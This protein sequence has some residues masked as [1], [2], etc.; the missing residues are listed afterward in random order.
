MKTRSLRLSPACAFVLLS[1]LLVPASFAQQKKPVIPSMGETMEISIVNVD[2]FVTDK[3]GNRVRGLKKEDFEI[4]ENG[5]KQPISNFA[6]YTSGATGEFTATTPGDTP[7]ESTVSA[8]PPQ[9]RTFMVFL[10]RMKLPEHQA[11]PFINSIKD[12][13]HKSVRPG[14]AVAVL[15]WG[16]RENM[17]LDFTGNMQSV[18]KTLDAIA[19]DMTGARFDLGQQL[20]EDVRAVR[21]FEQEVAAMAGGASATLDD[22]TAGNVAGNI[23]A[24]IAL[25]E[26]RRKVRAVNAA[27]LG[28]AGIEGKK[29]L[30]LATNRLGEY[31]GA[32]FFYAA[33]AD[34]LTPEAKQRF[35]TESLLKSMIDNANASGV[36]IYPLYAPG[37]SSTMNDASNNLTLD[38]RLD[39]LTLLNE[40]FALEQIAKKTGGLTATNVSDIVKLLPRVQEDVSDYYSLAY[41]IDGTKKDRARD[42]LV[43]TKNPQLQVRT[44]RQYVEK[45][46][47]TRMK[48]RVL[49]TLFRPVEQPPIAITATLGQPKKSGRTETVPLAVRV[50]I[51]ALTFIPQ[52]NGKMA[53]AF[54]VYVVTGAGGVEETSEITFKT[55]PFDFPEAQVQ[56]AM[57]GHFT[58]NL[59]IVVNKAADRIAVGVQDELS[60]Q[61]GLLRLDLKAREPQRGTH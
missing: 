38:P 17:Q 57:A 53:G 7:T 52:G 20:R 6:E 13:L 21:Q 12:F 8:A 51:K 27:I 4:V 35:S 31:A 55:Q 23:Q 22:A 37:L 32:E 50:P 18:D 58:Y 48:D 16:E 28:M 1:F 11:R 9:K 5:R 44:R 33:G 40:T 43:K 14:D 45:S 15:I 24:Q 34:T 26:I 25:N 59:D 60:K 39:H 36:T 2:V 49:A 29:V 10:E 61:Y 46:D 54:S 42:I 3:A 41:R 47:E 19:K 56:Q 30:M